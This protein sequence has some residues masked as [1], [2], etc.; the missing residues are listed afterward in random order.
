MRLRNKKTGEIVE[1]KTP[2]CMV[3]E[4]YSYQYDSLAELNDEW[5]DYEEPKKYWYITG[6][7]DIC[8]DDIKHSEWI[9]ERKSIGNYFETE[10]QT[11][12]AVEKLKAIT[13]LNKCNFKF[14]GYADRDRAKGGDIVI[15][16][17]VDIPN[18]NLLEEAQPAMLKDLD[19]LFS[20]GEE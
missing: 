18:D 7:G 13:R 4:K 10:E 1:F 8:R 20:G 16:A 15:Y 5:E 11:G 12:K 3:D 19:L 17:H 2:A 9:E 14:D 6:E